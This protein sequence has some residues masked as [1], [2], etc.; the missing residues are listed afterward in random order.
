MIIVNIGIIIGLESS[1]KM[2]SSSETTCGDEMLRSLGLAWKNI[3]EANIKNCQVWAMSKSEFITVFSLL[4][5][6][7]GSFHNELFKK[8]TYPHY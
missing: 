4:L 1:K 2:S 6:A 5:R 8:N 7:F 3:A